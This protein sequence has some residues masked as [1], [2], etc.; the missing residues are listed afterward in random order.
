MRGLYDE[1]PL[2]GILDLIF[3]M[4]WQYTKLLYFDFCFNLVVVI[5]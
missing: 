3:C 5:A 1:G 2:L 4:L